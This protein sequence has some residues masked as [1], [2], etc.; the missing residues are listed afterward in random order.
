L[1]YN[2]ETTVL[3]DFDA[4]ASDVY[5][6]SKVLKTKAFISEKSLDA[7]FLGS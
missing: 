6:F 5:A 4:L 7:L 3:P 1:A 2:P